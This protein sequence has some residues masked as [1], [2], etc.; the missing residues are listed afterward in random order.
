MKKGKIRHMFLG[1][2]T[3]QGFFSYYDYIL[4]QEE[5]DR[6]I[7]I[8]GGPGVGKSTFMKKIGEEFHHI[9]Y[10]LEYMHCSSDS[11]SID[12]IV[13]PAKKVALLDGTAPHVVDPKNPGVVDEIIHLGDF[14][15]EEGIR[16]NKDKI[17]KVNREVGENFKRAYR[18]IK[19]AY[20]LYQDSS[21]MI[22]QSVNIS[23]VNKI[24]QEFID[25]ILKDRE[26]SD[27]MGRDRRL[28]ASA[29]TPKGLVHY[30]STVLDTNK[31][32]CVS[33]KSGTGTEIFL[34][35]IKNAA[36][37]RAFDVESFYCALDPSKLEH[38]T[39][40]ELNISFTTSNE[41]HSTEVKFEECID[42]DKYIDKFFINELVL[43]EN[44]QNFGIL[45]G[46][47]IKNIA[48]A[49]SLHDDVEAYYIPNM[50]F[51]AVQLCL[52]STL[53]KIL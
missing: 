19:A 41:Y 2:N 8:K 37:E 42:F 16:K 21:E 49:K 15:D 24:S 45:L 6:I 11:E 34:E 3:S 22:K 18:Y 32:Y 1:G 31:I 35:K 48:K 27:K 13:I 39:I 5:A 44:K 28:F 47:A 4:S 17:M 25:M 20:L 52:E 50:D 9:G 46:L 40:R 29:I 10:E 23:K 51:E 53:A 43:E 38:L 12:G 36:L 7:C 14:W 26:V 30:L 33:G